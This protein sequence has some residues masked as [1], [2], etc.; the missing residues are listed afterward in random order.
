MNER[1]N[2][3][4]KTNM[5]ATR[6]AIHT[7]WSIVVLF[8]LTGTR[9]EALVDKTWMAEQQQQEEWASSSLLTT[10]CRG[11]CVQ[12]CRNYI[13]PL[14]QCYNGRELFPSDPSW[15]E[16]DILD[17]IIMSNDDGNDDSS[18]ERF[19]FDSTDKSC[20]NVVDY[21]VLP[22]NTCVG[23]FGAPRPWGTFTIIE[24]VAEGIQ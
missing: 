8:C 7:S 3:S 23:P 9:Q 19:I 16:F 4:Q 10:L 17:T 20:R 18:L 21:F 22:T 2:K 6:R 11:Q 14:H 12:D 13:T 5:L 1:T 15:S 24:A